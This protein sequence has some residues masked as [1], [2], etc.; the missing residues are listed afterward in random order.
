MRELNKELLEAMADAAFTCRIEGEEHT[1]HVLEDF[2]ESFSAKATRPTP[3]VNQELLQ[4]VKDFVDY[5]QE[6]RL[7]DRVCND[8][9]GHIDA[10]QSEELVMLFDRAKQAISKANAQAQQDGELKEWGYLKEQTAE[11]RAENSGYWYTC[12]GCYEGGEYGGNNHNYHTSIIF[13]TKMGTGCPECGGLGVRWDDT[14]YEKLY[15]DKPQAQQVK[16]GE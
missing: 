16:E 12:S 13:N 5:G 15:G 6:T 11:Q 7:Y 8:G 3:S 2:I 1:A 14:D 9:N 4:L 10:F